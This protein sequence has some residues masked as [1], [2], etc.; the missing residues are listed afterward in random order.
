[1]VPAKGDKAANSPACASTPPEPGV[2]YTTYGTSQRIVD[3]TAVPLGGVRHRT[4]STTLDNSC[5]TACAH[6]GFF[7]PFLFQT[8]PATHTCY[9]CVGLTCGVLG[10]ESW[11][12]EISAPDIPFLP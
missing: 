6:V 3:A 7:A 1:M 4:L 10:N 2:G 5:Y 12:D 9:W 11:P 8:D